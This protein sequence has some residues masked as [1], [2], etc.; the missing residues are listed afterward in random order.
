MH[1]IYINQW[2]ELLFD[3]FLF[4]VV[5]QKIP[6]NQ[7]PESKVI[8]SNFSKDKRTNYPLE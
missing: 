7:A 1:L 2:F 5:Y 4:M 6:Q 3:A 8:G